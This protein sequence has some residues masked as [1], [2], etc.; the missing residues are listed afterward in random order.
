MC[1]SNRSGMPSDWTRLVTCDL[2]LCTVN[3]SRVLHMVVVKD[4]H[5]FDQ[6]ARA[7]L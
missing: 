4:T 7:M 1:V 6:V 5:I 3:E 2:L